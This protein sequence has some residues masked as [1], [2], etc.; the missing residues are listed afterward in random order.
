MRGAPVLVERSLGRKKGVVQAGLPVSALERDDVWLIQG[1]SLWA[2]FL[3]QA[4]CWVMEAG[5]HGKALFDGPA[6]AGC[7]GGG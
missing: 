5:E 1:D 4:A 7:G 2:D 6:R 3:I